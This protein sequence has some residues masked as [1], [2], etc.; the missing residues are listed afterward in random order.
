[1]QKKK[2]KNEENWRK[3]LWERGK[4]LFK[5]A[6][7]LGNMSRKGSKM[8]KRSAGKSRKKRNKGKEKCCHRGGKKTICEGKGEGG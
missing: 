5:E 7:G 8:R 4:A 3:L 2:E 1:M 6:W